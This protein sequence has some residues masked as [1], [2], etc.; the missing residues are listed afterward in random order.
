M[1]G[2]LDAVAVA[3]IEDAFDGVDDLGLLAVKGRCQLPFRKR[4]AEIG[5]A[6]INPV[7]AGGGGDLLEIV[8]RLRRF[9]H[10]KGEDLVIGLRGIIAAGGVN[11]AGGA[12]AAFPER[13]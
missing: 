8:H 13:G 7:E 6:D 3:G 1:E 4:E 2:R 5:G 12:E 10:R 9:D 11:G